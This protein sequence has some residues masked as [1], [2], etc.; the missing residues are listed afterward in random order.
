MTGSHTSFDLGAFLEQAAQEGQTESVGEFTVDQDQAARKL[1]RFALPRP[2]SWVLKLVQAAV[3]WQAEALKVVQS[4]TLTS[5]FFRPCDSHPLPTMEEVVRTLVSGDIGGALPIQRLAI[6]MRALVEQAGFS[7]ILA[8][9]DGE[10][11][12][13][14]Y[15]GQDFSEMSEAERM[16]RAALDLRGICLHVS[17]LRGGEAITGRIL[18]GVLTAGG[19]RDIELAQEL[20]RGACLCPIPLTLDGRRI[21]GVLAHPDHGFARGKRMLLMSGVNPQERP[22]ML[23]PEEFEKREMSFAT[24]P[25]RARRGY[26]G[27]REFQAWY[28]LR[29]PGDG[30]QGAQRHIYFYWVQDGVVVERQRVSVDELLHCCTLEVFLSAQDLRTDLT[31]LRLVDSAEK[32]QRLEAA[33]EAIVKELKVYGEDLTVFFQSDQDAQSEKDQI[34]RKEAR[35]HGRVRRL[36]LTAIPLAASVLMPVF[37]A[38]ATVSVGAL[39]YLG[40][41]WPDSHQ[42]SFGRTQWRNSLKNDFKEIKRAQRKKIPPTDFDG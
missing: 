3:G 34:I 10:N 26:S 6:A 33:F 12:Q 13:S 32:Q 29:V 21:D 35:S 30:E 20:E 15:A 14:V 42:H 41:I 31:G 4:R 18:G 39:V 9:S 25:L 11:S 37:G 22:P 23:V 40:D 38:V 2:Y 36:G 17:L 28:T 19:R 1:A 5:F 24:D 7:F 16:E 27:E 8:I